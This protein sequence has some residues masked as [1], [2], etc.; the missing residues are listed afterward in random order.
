[1][2]RVPNKFLAMLQ[3]ILTAD[4][5]ENFSQSLSVNGPLNLCNKIY[6]LQ[7]E[8]IYRQDNLIY[9]YNHWMSYLTNLK[10]EKLQYILLI[11][12]HTVYEEHAILTDPNIVL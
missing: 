4:I 6:A 8:H 9:S 10:L 3:T 12:L 1:M 5:T 2:D 7:M 11:S